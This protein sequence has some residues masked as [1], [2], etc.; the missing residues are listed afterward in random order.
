MVGSTIRIQHNT[1][2]EERCQ[3]QIHGSVGLTRRAGM[4]MSLMLK[5][6]RRT[7]PFGYQ[8]AGMAADIQE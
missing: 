5:R 8:K 2:K 3:G 6:L 1:S 4:D 7:G